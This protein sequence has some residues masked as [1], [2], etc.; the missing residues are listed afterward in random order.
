MYS[1][2]IENA[3]KS[4]NPQMFYSF[5]KKKE[6]EYDGVKTLVKELQLLLEHYL[7]FDELCTYQIL[8]ILIDKFEE[9]N[10]F[11]YL[12]TFADIFVESKRSMLVSNIKTLF[13][14]KNMTMVYN[15]VHKYG[16]RNEHSGMEQVIREIKSCVEEKDLNV[17]SH[18]YNLCTYEKDPVN[19]RW[20]W[21][22]VLNHLVEEKDLD[23]SKIL[24]R[25][26]RDKYASFVKHND[27]AYLINAF[28]LI[29]YSNEEESF[30]VLEKYVYFE[31]DD[32][33]HSVYILPV[34]R[35]IH[36][37]PVVFIHD[38]MT[39]EFIRENIVYKNT[40]INSRKICENS[41]QTTAIC[42][43]KGKRKDD[44]DHF[45]I[46]DFQLNNYRGILFMNVCDVRQLHLYLSL[47]IIHH[48]F[49]TKHVPFQIIQSDYRFTA[50]ADTNEVIWGIFDKKT[51]YVYI[52]YFTASHILLLK[53][54]VVYHSNSMH[55]KETMKQYFRLLFAYHVLQ[56]KH[57]KVNDM[58]IVIGRFNHNLLHYKHLDIGVKGLSTPIFQSGDLKWIGIY[59]KEF[60]ETYL[61]FENRVETITYQ[62]KQQTGLTKSRLK[63]CLTRVDKLRGQI[64]KEVGILELPPTPPS[65]PK[66]TYKIYGWKKRQRC[67]VDDKDDSVIF[68]NLVKK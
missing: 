35:D 20:I 53:D 19:P 54:Y 43:K 25:V 64:E 51:S 2:D 24:F 38:N 55:F 47:N 59:K 10:D 58:Y 3:I 11:A 9:N 28:L 48:S 27:I 13:S 44:L 42:T 32:L 68:Q 5:L 41:L 56:I 30:D 23:K 1:P 26:V 14:D 22:N 21:K 62:L 18:V 52:P 36:D 61:D 45:P 31:L 17:F 33:D 34:E 50:N 60:M 63:S 40:V 66:D 12:Y 7:F 67:D 39:N 6:T 37:T 57:P 46:V 49:K 8:L 65:S 16:K 15:Y 4:A 29:M